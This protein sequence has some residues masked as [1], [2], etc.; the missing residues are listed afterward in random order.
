MIVVSDAT[1]IISFL[2]INRLDILETLFGEVLLPDAVYEELT[3]NLNFQVEADKVRSCD[4]FKR[5]SIA[6]SDTVNMLMRMTGLDLGESE[7]IVYSDENKCDLLIVDEVRARH[8]ATTMKLRIS[9][10][11]G[12]LTVANEKGLLCKA[13][14]IECARI[15]RLSKRHISEALLNSFVENLK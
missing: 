8:V 13:D 7:A 15:L 9:G 6:N 1:P 5:V 3:S 10:T 4:F 14:A 2:K 11:I 12:I